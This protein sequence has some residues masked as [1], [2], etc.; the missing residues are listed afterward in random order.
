MR[1]SKD[2]YGEPTPKQYGALVGLYDRPP[3]RDWLVWWSIA[4]T[5]IAIFSIV[6]PTEPLETRMPVWLNA[7]LSAVTVYAL[8]GFIPA[9]VRRQ[10]RRR[11]IRRAR[12]ERLLGRSMGPEAAPSPPHETVPRPTTP[13]RSAAATAEAKPSTAPQPAPDREPPSSRQPPP[14][15]AG[16]PSAP[17]MTSVAGFELA[18]VRDSEALTWAR[19]A[20]PYPIARAARSVQ[21][22][23]D[24]K[25]AYEAIL[26]AADATTTV[27]GITATAWARHNGAVTRDLDELQEAFAGRGISQGL[28]RSVFVSV[29][30]AMQEHPMALHGMA[31]AVRSGRGGTWL[32]SDLQKLTEERNLWAHGAGPHDRMEAAERLAQFVPLLERALQEL[33]FLAEIPWVLVNDAK[34]RR[35]TDD[36]QVHAS[37]AMGD[38]PD[39]DVMEFTVANP[40]AEDVFYLLTTHGLIDLAPL[41]VMEQCTTCHQRELAYA[42][43]I[44]D[45]R[46]VVL[47]TFDRGH[48]IFDPQLVDEIRNLIP[49]GGAP[50]HNHAG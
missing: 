28:W 14:T 30:R 35:R 13:P 12:A 10:I 17:P 3:H 36:F 49:R 15:S 26:R 18:R 37:K 39:F 5:L 4:W 27:L 31:E 47:K 32:K 43:K 45:K 41:V 25:D 21:L 34:L 48:V 19:G 8:L 42:D 44:D 38:H 22:A 6:F 7:A 33:A 24:S 40:V 50:Q 11:R 46:G 1:S 2:P 16:Q 9:Q 23:A 29:G 20:L